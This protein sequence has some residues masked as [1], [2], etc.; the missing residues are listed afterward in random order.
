MNPQ[1]TL[2]RKIGYVA[3]MVLIAMLLA[4]LGTPPVQRGAG[5]TREVTGG[6]VLSDLRAKHKLSEAQ[7]GELDPVGQT[8]K[9]AT[10]GLRGVAVTLL[11]DRA[12]TCKMKKDWTNYAAALE[13]ILKLEPHFIKVWEHQA[14]NVSY[15]VA[16]EFDDY[17]E[18]YRWL[19]RGIDFLKEGMRY[20]QD[21]YRLV[22]KV[23]ETLGRKMGRADEAVLYRQLFK[24]DDEFHGD[25]PLELRDNWLVA[26]QWHQRAVA[27]V[28]AA[29]DP[30]D[31][32]K[33]ATPVIFYRDPPMCQMNYS[34]FVEKDGVFGE[35]AQLSWRQAGEE[36]REFGARQIPIGNG[37]YVV[38]NDK[39]DHDKEAVRLKKELDDLEPGLREKIRKE[40]YDA[41]KPEEKRI[42]DMPLLQITSQQDGEQRMR[43]DYQL[44]V[45]HDQL[46]RRISKN[47]Q[48]ALELARQCNKAEES[49]RRIER[50]RD[51]VSFAN[52][53]RTATLEQMA[54][55]RAARE[56][57]YLAREAYREGEQQKAKRLYA[58]SFR[59]WRRVF[60]D[61]RW[62]DLIK[63]E[64]FCD[65]V[66][67]AMKRYR[68]VLASMD[69]KIPA[70]F[71]L[72]E[73]LPLLDR[74][75]APSKVDPAKA[76][77][78]KPNPAKAT[79]DKK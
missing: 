6:G 18:R 41:L 57:A 68:K 9:L 4:Q 27:I 74:E 62:P 3:G 31:R 8:M 14:W 36:W 25:R 39:E 71:P 55:T 72:K 59:L 73:L 49:A 38:L 22:N 45:N 58:D 23:G 50:E 61:K 7:I 17:R 33:K 10:L 40:R 67:D 13:Q 46:A 28:D 24:Q 52:W 44:E 2:K 1:R 54:E 32:L 47:K 21:E 34:E 56:A 70:D 48:K 65:D 15:N 19:L 77:S 12:E 26:K 60:D 64:V 75:K 51:L 69:E 63:D 20:N 53:R 5:A 43:L 35:K 78:E 42:V 30:I 76:T 29:P 37:E 79:S 11:S 66:V 16:V